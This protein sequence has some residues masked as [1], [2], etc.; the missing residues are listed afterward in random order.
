MSELVTSIPPFK[1]T[2]QVTTTDGI[3]KFV[4]M[5]DADMFNGKKIVI[6]GLPGAFT[7]TCSGQQLQ[8]MRN[9][10]MSLDKQVSMIS[11][12]LQ[13]MIHLSVMSGQ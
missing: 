4:E 2:K 7:P 3:S 6:F 13:L 8:G 12:V 10:I 5:N 9:Y 1:I 11:I